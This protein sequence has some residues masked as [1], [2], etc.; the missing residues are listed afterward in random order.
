MITLATW[1]LWVHILAAAVWLG[2]AAAI[3][4]TLGPA[5]PVALDVLRRVRFLGS[6]AMEILVLTG[7]LNVIVKGVGTEFAFQ[8]GFFAM[9]AIKMAFLVTMAGLQIWMGLAFQRTDVIVTSTVRRARLG[10]G[11]QF[12]LGAVASL[13]GLGLRAV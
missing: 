4:V 12:V 9:L 7:I 2:G 6:R 13:L 8:A 10:L 5:G 11:L 3:L 1:I